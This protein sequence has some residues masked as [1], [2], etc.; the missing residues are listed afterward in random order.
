[1]DDAGRGMAHE[2]AHTEWTELLV[3]TLLIGYK[4]KSVVKLLVLGR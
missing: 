4:P 1:M 2:P 3:T